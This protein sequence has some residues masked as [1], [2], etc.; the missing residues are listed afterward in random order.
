M[1]GK[2]EGGR[3]G[4]KINKTNRQ[5]NLPNQKPVISHLEIS[6]ALFQIMLDR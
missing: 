3:D 5:K 2:K 1:E 4:G 6:S